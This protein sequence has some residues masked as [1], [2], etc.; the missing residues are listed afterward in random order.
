MRPRCPPA[1]QL[2]IREDEVTLKHVPGFLIHDKLSPR[3]IFRSDDKTPGDGF[4]A[5]WNQNC[6][7]VFK[8]DSTKRVLSSPGFPKAYG[9]NLLCNYT[10]V[11]PPKSYINMNFLEFAVE[12]TGTKCLYDNVTIYKIPDYAAYPYQIP[13]DKLGTFCGLTGPKSL[14][15]R[16]V[17]TLIFQSD[18]WVERKGFSLEY[19]VEE[20]GGIITSPSMIQSPKIVTTTAYLGSM[21]C[22][23]NITAPVGK[24][25]VVKFENF[26]MEM[27]NYCSFDF[28]E[29]YNG[30]KVN[31]TNRLAKIC[32]NLTNSIRPIVLEGN[33]ALLL[34][35]TDQA[36]VD[37]VFNA[38]ISFKPKCD[39]TIQLSSAKPSHLLDMSNQVHLE[40]MECVFKVV[41]EPIGSIRMTL[42]SIHLSR[43]DD[44]KQNGTCDYN[45]LEVH[46]GNGPFSSLIGTYCGHTIP[47]DVVSSSSAMYVRFASESTSSGFK[48]TFSIIASPCG[49][50]PYKNFT[51]NETSPF[52]LDF[53]KL[54]TDKYP[55]NTR[56]AWQME[57]P[58]GKI[59][60]IQF[61]NFELE[62]SPDCVND[63][64]TIEDDNVKEYVTEGF[65]QEV[66][67]RGQSQTSYQPSFY[68]GISG[69]TAPHVYCGSVI[70]HD[71]ISETNKI[72]IRF[73]SNSVNE[74][75]GFSFT[76]KTMSSCA[77]NFTALTGRLVSTDVMPDCKTTIKVPANH[78]ISLFFHRFF[79]YEQDCTKSFLKVYDGTFEDGMLLQTLCGY[80]MPNPIFST[81]NQ[82]SLFFHYDD[83]TTYYS[84]GNYDIMFIATDKG[85]GCGGSIYNYGGVF[86]SPLYP[87]NNR[88]M[89]DCTW[90]VTVPQN[91]RVAVRF[92]GE[93]PSKE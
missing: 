40:S 61:L 63:S 50:H 89:Y 90:T 6:G 15:H 60:D 37:I 38:A 92:S 68:S 88:S 42:S 91:L 11:A 76:V 23:W 46:D 41:G 58:Y 4:S 1:I 22:I 35:K 78:T 73:N 28:V 32:G 48:A 19:Q 77:R 84:K 36:N 69:P 71:Y 65:G 8:V 2:D 51:G 5:V 56:C 79:F 54:A 17:I 26:S 30:T 93:F 39:Q 21:Q 10:F 80:A 57:A 29:I 82:L 3:V 45:Y 64:L 9:P 27:S 75:K 66:I 85:R 83:G 67:Y 81:K 31:E 70:P 52:K 33:Q 24:K 86:T 14:R 53:P 20:C 49:Y 47:H 16:D 87:S 72:K 13:M 7:G 34:F 55:T 59:F 62:D 43:R 25:I 44:T 12:T 74:F 18:R